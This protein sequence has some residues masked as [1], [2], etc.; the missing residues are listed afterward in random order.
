MIWFTYEV[1]VSV[2]S[3]EYSMTLAKNNRYYMQSTAKAHTKHTQRTD[4]IDK[5][6]DMRIMYRLGTAVKEFGERHGF[7]WL[8]GVGYRIRGHVS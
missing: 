8:I 7:K 6:K 4:S 2:H 1:E 5:E 3:F